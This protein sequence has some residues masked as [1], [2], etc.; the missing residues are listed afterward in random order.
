MLTKSIIKLRA[1][2]RD[3]IKNQAS[4]PYILAPYQMFS[5]ISEPPYISDD[6]KEHKR[7]TIYL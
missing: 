2:T 1:L 6:T 3:R 5:T 7:T 4:N